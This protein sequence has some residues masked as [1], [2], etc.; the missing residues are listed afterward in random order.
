[1]RITK[2]LAWSGVASRRKAEQLIGE[3]R[4]K[5]NGRTVTEPFVRV[6]AGDEIRVDG[7]RVSR[8]EEKLYFLLDKPAGYLS[9]VADPYGRKTVMDLLPHREARLYPVGRL[10]RDSEG[11]LLMTNDGELAYR[12]THPKFLIPKT[13]RALVEGIPGPGQ[14]QQ[15]RDGLE[16][17]GVLT[18][19][20]KVKIK[21]REGSG[22]CWLEITIHEGRKRQVKQ[23]C[24]AIGH[25]VV[26]LRRTQFALLDA[27]GLKAGHYRRLDNE[28]VEQLYRLAGLK[29]G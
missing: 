25:P 6:S 7:I 8:P 29:P 21:K 22:R 19:P 26:K 28:E 5:L 13:Y 11:L 10:D 20:A 15:L 3:N 1:M 17:E 4:V 23:M 16:L 9:T 18:A 27:R 24:A 2:Y 14:L 12:L